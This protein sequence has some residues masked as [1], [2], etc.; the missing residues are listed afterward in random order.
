MKEIYEK[1]VSYQ[2]FNAFLDNVKK[3]KTD[4][5]IL[6]AGFQLVEDWK[7]FKYQRMATFVEKMIQEV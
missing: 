7:G 6:L 5:E 2:R 4:K 3:A 1:C